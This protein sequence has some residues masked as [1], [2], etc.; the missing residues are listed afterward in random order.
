RRMSPWQVDPQYGRFAG[1]LGLSADDRR[2][3][4]HWIERGAVRGTGE[5]ALAR[6][7][8]PLPEWPLGP[9]DLVVEMPEQ[10]IPATGVV[11]YRKAVGERPLETD[12]WVRAVDLRPSNASVLHHGFAF[13]R[14]QQEADVLRDRLSRLPPGGQKKMRAWLEKLGGTPEDPPPAALE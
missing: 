5:D 11:P 3:L 12:R 8:A 4:V 1:H 6:A 2:A 10:E 13:I 7:A 14:G 9:P